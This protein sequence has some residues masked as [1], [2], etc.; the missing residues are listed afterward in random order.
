MSLQASLLNLVLRFTFKRHSRGPLDALAIRAR[1]TKTARDLPLPQGIRREPVAADPARGLCAAEWLLPPSPRGTLLYCHGG[2]YFFC[3]LVTHRPT[4]AQLARRTGMRVLSLD[5][6]MAPEHPCPAAVD[7]TLA[8]WQHLLADGTLPGETVFAGDSAGGGLVV[9]S[10]LAAR[11]QGL[12]LPA[13]SLLFS[14]WA[15]LSCAGDSMRLNAR[16]DTMFAPEAL[17]QAAAFYLAGRSAE[18]PLASPLFGDLR[19]LPPMMLH[20]SS[21][22]VLLS[23]SERLHARALA[24]GVASELHIKPGM[25]HVWPTFITLPE[26]RA[27]LADSAAFALR[28]TGLQAQSANAA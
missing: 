2:G 6:R 15:D 26:A 13:G 16:S 27:S 7:D 12:A 11:Q 25:P 9:A 8:W 21:S 20:A 17:P 19:G 5:Y 24:H 3:D 28:V 23:D 1:V 18:D 22:E 4:A 10:L 14:P